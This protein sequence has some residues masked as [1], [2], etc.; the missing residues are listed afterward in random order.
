MLN[1]KPRYWALITLL[2]WG[3]IILAAGL[4]RLDAFGIE[5]SASR[6]ILLSWSIAEKV[7]STAFVFGFP[8]LRAILFIP[9]G[10]YWGGS[11]IAVKIFTLLVLF[12]SCLLLYSWNRRVASEE[13]ALLA[14]G[15]L[16]IAPIIISQT[17][18]IGTGPYLLLAFGLGMWLDHSYRNAQR[19]L[20]G[21]F[22]LQMLLII[23][24]VTLHPIGLALPIALIWEWQKNPLDKHH[25]QYLFIGTGIATTLAMLLGGGWETQ[26]WFNNP[27]TALH[28][29]LLGQESSIG[30]GTLWVT[31]IILSIL[32]G[33]LLVSERHNMLDNFMGRMMTLGV[34]IGLLTG[35]SA[36]TIMALTAL[37]YLGIPKLIAINNAMA[38][39]SLMGQRGLVLLAVFIVAVF[40]MQGDKAHQEKVSNNLLNPQDQLLFTLALELEENKNENFLAMSQWPGRSMLALKR[41][42]LPLPPDYPDEE[43]LM[44]K[45]AGATHLIFDPFSPGNQNLR[46]NLAKMS[47]VAKTIL[48]EEGGVVVAIE[49]PLANLDQPSPESGK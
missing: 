18:A 25:Q 8:D 23:F 49:K 31:G 46:D 6:A 2:V 1:I 5:E 48:L 24:T 21:W 39:Q 28:T 29:V 36:W 15:L 38:K 47:G 32:L 44:R 19:L 9:L 41:P 16:L 27:V 10:I 4:L 17:D 26:S 43:M 40:F 35:D 45:I 42:V 12:A 33:G 30:E 37:L 22:F 20:G 7:I 34:T 14:S 11:L 3:G 13:S